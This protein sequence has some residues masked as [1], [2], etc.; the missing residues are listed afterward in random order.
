LI[1][2][3]CAPARGRERSD[4]ST[5]PE[6]LLYTDGASRGNPG[7]AAIG[8]A[9]FD[10][11]GILI[12][13]DAKTIGRHTNNEAEYEA[14]L[15]GT[16][17][18]RE[19]GCGIVRV[20][21]DSELVVRQTSGAYDVNSDNLRVYAQKVAQNKKLFSS[22]QVMHAPRENPRIALVDALVNAVLDKEE[23]RRR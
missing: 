1:N 7:P 11:G 18:L 10:S 19:R 4:L 14:I 21:S 9:I 2:T 20:F 17:K 12:E 3:K 16:E 22:F 5:E 8:Y 15:W 6:L 23:D 13:K